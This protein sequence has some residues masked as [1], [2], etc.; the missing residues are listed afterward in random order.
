MLA[1]VGWSAGDPPA[2][3]G[4]GAAREAWEALAALATLADDL[5]AADPEADLAALVADLDRRA[6]VSQVPVADGVT[7]A[8]LH[9][10]KG[11]EW[12]A[13]FVVGLVDGTL[14][15]S[16]ADTPARVEEERR[17][18]Y[19]GITRA[20]RHLALSWARARTPGQRGSRSP[21]RF[22]SD[23]ASAATVASSD[24]AVRRGRGGKGERRRRGPA[25]CRVCGASLVTPPEKTL[26]RCRRCPATYDEALL[27]RL[28][29]WRREEAA[30]RSVPAYVVFTDATLQA[31]A[32]QR[33]TDDAGLVAIDGIGPAKLTRYGPACSPSSA[34]SSP[35]APPSRGPTA[36]W[37]RR[38]RTAPGP[39]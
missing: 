38:P 29:A 1:G 35:S 17:L 25:R 15:I 33:P 26:G 34:A 3:G 27:E 2:P 21:S 14:P 28:R 8:S 24:A 7:L 20:R 4:A 11:L 6:E 32:E 36:R 31:V 13:V 19:V 18:L 39:E 30:S 10:A 37:Y 12:D 9:A 16:Y 23:I 5:A 22:L